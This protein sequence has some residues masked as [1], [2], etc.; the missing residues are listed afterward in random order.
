MHLVDG[1]VLK[2]FL[3]LLRRIAE[4]SGKGTMTGIERHIKFLDKYRALDQARQLRFKNMYIL[5]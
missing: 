2:D 4:K 1:G 5:V 3:L